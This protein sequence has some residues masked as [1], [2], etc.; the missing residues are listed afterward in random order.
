VW[1][2]GTAT[3]CGVAKRA[4][5]RT[6][7]A[8]GSGCTIFLWILTGPNCVGGGATAVAREI[9]LTAGDGERIGTLLRWIL[10]GP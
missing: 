9:G 2:A 3:G 4:G 6:D 8:R 7:A 5:K 1:W 10:A